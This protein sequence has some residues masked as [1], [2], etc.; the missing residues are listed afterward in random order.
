MARQ[1]RVA[2]PSVDAYL[3]GLPPDQRAALEEL[4]ATIRAAAPMAEELIAYQIPAYRHRGMLVSFSA[5]SNHC[6]FHVMSPDTL[7]AHAAETEG[8]ETTTGGIHF[9]PE[10][11]IAAELVTKLVKARVAENERRGK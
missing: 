7:K 4:R 10:K 2:P 6:T 8:Y 1:P 3:A 11:P 9:T 5:H